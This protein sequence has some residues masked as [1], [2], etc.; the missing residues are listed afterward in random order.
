MLGDS[1]RMTTTRLLTIFVPAIVVYSLLLFVAFRPLTR[2]EGVRF[3]KSRT[4]I[5]TTTAEERSRG[6]SSFII[7][8]EHR[9]GITRSGFF[10]FA[11]F[12]YIAFLVGFMIAL[13]RTSPA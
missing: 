6:E 3:S 7:G 10:L 8:Q 11:A 4:P 1:T 5:D 12:G 13:L 2:P 9:F